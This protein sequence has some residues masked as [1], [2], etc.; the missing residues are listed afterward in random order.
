MSLPFFTADFSKAGFAG[1]CQHLH[2]GPPAAGQ[3]RL[4]AHAAADR[5]GH[6]W[7]AT[8]RPAP[9][10]CRRRCSLI[11]HDVLSHSI[12][13]RSQRDSRESDDVIQ[14]CL[15]GLSAYAKQAGSLSAGP[16]SGRIRGRHEFRCDLRCRT[17]GSISDP[18]ERS[19]QQARVA[20]ATDGLAR[21]SRKLLVFALEEDG[22]Q[23]QL[24]EID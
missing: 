8:R 19:Q 14:D 11:M 2:R 10:C 22:S 15:L 17:E 3:S 13:C 24:S 23:L 9:P 4:R 7:R 18:H 5:P 20:E 16:S 21:A 6:A 12:G 1:Q